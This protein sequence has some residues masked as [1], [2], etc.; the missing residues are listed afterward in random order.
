MAAPSTQIYM[1]VHVLVHNF[2]WKIHTIMVQPNMH[3]NCDLWVSIKRNGIANVVI[4]RVR[5]LLGISR[6]LGY[7]QKFSWNLGAWHL[8]AP[9]VSNP[10]KFLHKNL[11]SNILRKFSPV[12]VSHYTVIDLTSSNGDKNRVGSIAVKKYRHA[13]F[14]E[15]GKESCANVSF[16]I[17]FLFL[18][19]NTLMLFWCWLWRLQHATMVPPS[20]LMSLASGTIL[21]GCWNQGLL[22]A[23]KMINFTIINYLTL[24]CKSVYSY[25]YM[26]VS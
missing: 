15:R 22:A 7:S 16:P 24:P 26:Y 2:H 23:P 25:M 17:T 12:K 8:L 9:A 18:T 19:A 4:H 5:K 13:P 21:R 10:Q 1:C 20:T 6:I 11:F 3:H 14:H